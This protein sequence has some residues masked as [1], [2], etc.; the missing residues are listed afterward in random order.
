MDKVPR[1]CNQKRLNQ[2]FTLQQTENE[3]NTFDAKNLDLNFFFR[4]CSV[5]LI[6]LILYII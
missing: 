4:T 2:K 6:H 1:M 5:C 3:Y